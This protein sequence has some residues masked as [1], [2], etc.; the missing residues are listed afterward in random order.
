MRKR[1]TWQH[2]VALRLIALAGIAL[3]LQGCILNDADLDRFWKSC[4]FDLVEANICPEKSVYRVKGVCVADSTS[5]MGGFYAFT[6]RMTYNAESQKAAENYEIKPLPFPPSSL[7]KGEAWLTVKCS[8]DPFRTANTTCWDK[9]FLSTYK[10]IPGPLFQ[11]LTQA[12]PVAN[13][14]FSAAEIAPFEATSSCKADDPP[15]PDPP[16]PPLPP[17]CERETEPTLIVTSPGS[18]QPIVFPAARVVT[19]AVG[20]T[21]ESIRAVEIQWQKVQGRGFVD[22]GGL[23]ET[24]AFASLPLQIQ[25]TDPDKGSG[26]G[27]FRVRVRPLDRNCP[28]LW[29][30]WQ[31]FELVGGGMELMSR[32][33][34]R[35]DRSG[36]GGGTD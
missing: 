13:E 33:R 12:E 4:N 11:A 28:R 25:L 22:Q 14:Q 24:V 17:E 18:R 8:A 2:P 9:K 31:E 23:P 35:S 6:G 19:L 36:R 26:P 27:Q 21:R 29:S 20:P 30:F 5:G 34:S 1:P 3:A 10:T 16:D 32:Q 15:P 7:G